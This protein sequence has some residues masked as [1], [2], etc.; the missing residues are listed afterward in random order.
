[1]INL[2]VIIP[3][4]NEEYFLEA[5]INRL[6][7]N[8]IYEKIILVNDS[9]TDNSKTIAEKLCRKYKKIIYLETES[10]L[11]KG[12]ALNVGLEN[13]ETSHIVIHDADLEYFPEDIVSMFELSKKNE[14]SL[15][16]GSR[17]IGNKERKNIYKRT[18]FSNLFLS[19]FFSLVNLINVSDVATCYKLLPMRFFEEFNLVEKGF[20]IEVELLS[21]Y[22]KYNKSIVE[23]PIKYAGRSYEEG[24]KIKF[25]DGI[26]YI[27]S[28]IKYRFLN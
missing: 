16:L 21:K 10:N 15:I 20:S 13:V 22:I 4:Y 23:T 6:I 12:H 11:G 3:I 28:I 26:R 1:M 25:I 8:D 27:K 2:S 9:S 19:K 18:Y 5:S 14:N 17:F 7:E 24:K